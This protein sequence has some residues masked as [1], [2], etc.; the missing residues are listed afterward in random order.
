MSGMLK[1]E[2]KGW[3]IEG[4]DEDRTGIAIPDGQA[5]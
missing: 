3:C 4:E 5:E 1:R 2:Q